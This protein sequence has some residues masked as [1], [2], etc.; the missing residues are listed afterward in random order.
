MSF[1]KLLHKLF[2]PPKTSPKKLSYKGTFLPEGKQQEIIFPDLNSVDMESSFSS[3]N[4][5]DT[6]GPYQIKKWFYNVGDIIEEGD[7]LCAIETEK[8]TM[9][10]EVAIGGQV[11]FINQK[12]GTV[13]PGE[14]LATLT[15]IQTKSTHLKSYD[16]SKPWAIMVFHQ[17]TRIRSKYAGEI[18]FGPAFLH[19]KSEP[20]NVFG[21]Q[22]FGDWFYKTQQ[23]I[24][25]Q[26]WNSNPIKEGVHTKANNDLLFLNTETKELTTIKKGIP[27][28]FWSI[29]ENEHGKLFLVY[30][31]DNREKRI[32][33]A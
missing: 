25:L 9:E 1:L 14:T 30:D 5:I 22:F 21:N 16:N 28:F 11:S 7:V 6:G 31:T 24:Y 32:E 10:F 29:E 12:K 15:G 20:I 17:G 26:L 8:V 4:S 33:I 27:S 19:L 18:R 3:K 2:F 23:G 13:S